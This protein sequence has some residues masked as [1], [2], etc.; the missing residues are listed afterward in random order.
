MSRQALFVVRVRMRSIV[1]ISESRNGTAV[2][3]V[4]AS[5]CGFGGERMLVLGATVVAFVVLLADVWG[6]S[7]S[8]GVCRAFFG[9]MLV[10]ALLSFLV[11]LWLLLT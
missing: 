8:R 1:R 4:V 2:L 6:Y 9:V 10:V 5:S 7:L 11:G 3:L